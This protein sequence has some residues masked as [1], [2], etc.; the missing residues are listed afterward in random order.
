[1]VDHRQQ[2]LVRARERM[3]VDVARHTPRL[4]MISGWNCIAA[5]P[6]K[7]RLGDFLYL[8]LIRMLEDHSSELP[9]IRQDSWTG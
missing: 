3:T 9:E 6:L 8:G 7:S 4:E 1:M 5:E 2:K